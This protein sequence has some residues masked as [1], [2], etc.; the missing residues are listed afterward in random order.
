MKDTKILVLAALLC[1]LFIAVQ[2]APWKGLYTSSRSYVVHLSRQNFD[3]V[4]TKNRELG[5][6]I[7]HYYKRND[8]G[9]EQL[10]RELDDSANEMNG[11]FKYAAVN[12]DENADVCTKEGV[13]KFPTVRIYPPFP[14]PVY[15]HE[16]DLSSKDIVAQA[17]KYVPG[18]RV[19]EI[20]AT[21]HSRF[22][23][24]NP[25]VPKV[26][27][28]TEKKGVPL[29]YRALSIALDKKIFLGVV[30]SSEADLV[31]K[32]KVKEYPTILV[33]KT[34]EPK[35]IF[36]KGDIKYQQIFEFLNVYAETFV[37][38]GDKL[39][40]NKPWLNEAVPE[41]TSK[42]ASDLALKT[43]GKLNVIY[44]SKEAPDDSVKDQITPL[45]TNNKYEN[46]KYSWLNVDLE[47]QWAKLFNKVDEYPKIVVVS[48]GKRKKYVVHE[49][50]LT[51]SGIS[52][53][54]EKINNGDAHFITIKGEV[55]TFQH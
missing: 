4:I 13:K 1:S 11:I 31:K 48:F 53:T 37:P 44:L 47:P 35:P 30:R 22:V 17:G 3:K 27:L 23:D 24:D 7:V 42:S 49:Y 15:D 50:D 38:G 18:Q 32:Y 12:C 39:N 29:I 36:Y 34:N 51:T 55:P 16:G 43:D 26:L 28:F 41:L 8:D 25:S 54:L 52:S 46:Y 5:V 10:A 14:V 40:T 2:S 9:S 20:N 19:K 6:S 21:T 33:I 45:I